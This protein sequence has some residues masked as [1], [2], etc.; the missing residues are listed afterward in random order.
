MSDAHMQ[1]MLTH[2]GNKGAE[3]KGRKE[4]CIQIQHAKTIG[5]N[6]E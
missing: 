3:Q 5:E 4:I 1:R 2:Q 6:R